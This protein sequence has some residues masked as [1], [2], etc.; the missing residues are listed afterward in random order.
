MRQFRD[1]IV[2]HGANSACVKIQKFMKGYLVSRKFEPVKINLRLNKNFDFF[3]EMKEHLRE[4]AQVTIAY[5]WRKFKKTKRLRKKRSGGGTSSRN[6]R[7]SAKASDA[8]SSHQGAKGRGDGLSKTLQGGRTGDDASNYSYKKG[9][10]LRHTQKQSFTQ[11]KGR[12]LK[13]VSGIP[14]TDSNM[15]R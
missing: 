4:S 12:N 3:D 11:A 13:S 2:N 9:S 5:Y 15:K 6:L 14:P 1:G 7:Q 10:T 8:S